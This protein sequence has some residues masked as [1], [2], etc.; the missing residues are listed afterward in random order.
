[1][2]RLLMQR[3]SGCPRYCGCPRYLTLLASG[4]MK[5]NSRVPLAP[6]EFKDMYEIEQIKNG[7]KW[8]PV[9]AY[10]QKFPR[11]VAVDTWRLKM[12]VT[13]RAEEPMPDE[14]QRAVLL[15]SIRGLNGEGRVYNE[16]VQ[17][18]NQIGW[19]SID[20]DQHIRVTQRAKG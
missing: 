2:L 13:R 20:V 19:S 5:F 18:M 14:P 7:F 3:A 17:A 11:G 12:K 9:K 6:N 4:K 15:I 16:T 8:S 10:H 1:M